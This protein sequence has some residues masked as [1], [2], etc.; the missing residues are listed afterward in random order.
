MQSDCYISLVALKAIVQS[1]IAA[2]TTVSFVTSSHS[3]P[4]SAHL[5]GFQ[6]SLPPRA[7]VAECYQ[8]LA[9]MPKRPGELVF[10][11]A[12]EPTIYLDDVLAI[13]AALRTSGIPVRLNTNGQ[14]GLLYPGKEVV[15][16]LA[17]AGLSALS[18]SLNATM[19]RTCA[20]PRSRRQTCDLQT[21]AKKARCQ[22]SRSRGNPGREPLVL[23][24]VMTAAHTPKKRSLGLISC[25]CLSCPEI[26]LVVATF[27]T[28]RT[29]CGQELWLFLDDWNSK[30]NPLTLF[31][32][33][34]RLSLDKFEPAI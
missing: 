22:K 7:V 2:R 16:E 26:C 10:C 13:T 4:L 28:A 33:D 23:P 11:G 20:L 25:S 30:P 29:D 19:L 27:R 24:P 31:L 21:L 1:T 8:K 15:A 32:R 3:R 17:K 5:S 6:R 14:A 18:I 34:F 9:E 12:G